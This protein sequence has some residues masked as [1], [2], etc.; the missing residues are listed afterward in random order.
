MATVAE[1]VAAY[2]N[3]K[4]RGEILL[5]LKADETAL[6]DSLVAARILSPASEYDRKAIS[7]AAERVLEIFTKEKI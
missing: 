2:K 4:R 6:V 7:R 5:T 3:R 1:R